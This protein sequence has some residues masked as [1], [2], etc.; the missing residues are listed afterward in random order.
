MEWP[1]IVQELDRIKCKM[2]VT[3]VQWE[4]PE[5]G[6]VK[7]NADEAFRGAEDKSSYAYCLRDHTG[8]LIYA[9]AE[10]HTHADSLQAEANAIL[11]AAKHCRNTHFDKVI[12]QMD[13]LLMQKI[14]TGSWQVP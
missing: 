5:Q 13:S 2:R 4:I 10:T 7:Y 8:D 3:I 9:H 14:L 6:W 11:Q 12:F 1:Q